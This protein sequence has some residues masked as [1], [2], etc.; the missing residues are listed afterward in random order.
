MVQMFFF[1][2]LFLP[3]TSHWKIYKTKSHV[4]QTCQYSTDLFKIYVYFILHYKTIQLSYFTILTHEKV[5]QERNDF[6]K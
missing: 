2:C 4:V 5:C 1:V 6:K 3:T